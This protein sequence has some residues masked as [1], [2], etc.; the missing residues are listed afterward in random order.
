MRK[1]Q[2]PSSILSLVLAA[3]LAVAGETPAGAQQAPDVLPSARL[4]VE[5][6]PYSNSFSSF[7]EVAID[8]DTA[9]IAS[10]LPDLSRGSAW[11]FRR[12]RQGWRQEARLAPAPGETMPGLGF[13]CSVAISGAT[14]AVGA[15][16]NGV[17]VFT[18]DAGAWR[19]QALLP[20]QRFSSSFGQE[21]A[22]SGD[23]ILVSSTNAAS[24]VV[25]SGAFAFARTGDTWRLDGSFVDET[26]NSYGQSVA[27]SDNL[28]AVGSSDAID[29]FVHGRGAWHPRARIVGDVG[30]SSLLAFSGTTLAAA[31]AFDRVVK[32]FIWR[33]GTWHSD[34][35]MA[36][37]ALGSMALDG[38]TLVLAARSGPVLVYGR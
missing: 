35:E 9:V 30:G 13:G 15:L 21:V 16:S 20:A 36:F 23:R 28:A 27:L 1:A 34:G 10:A 38:D 31:D 3:S 17:F 8:G 24:Q 7:R 6:L 25:G 26:S 32:I 19:E 12:T 29:L 18:D 5:P 37:E 2:R 11:V 33:Q 22:I 14:I 4:A